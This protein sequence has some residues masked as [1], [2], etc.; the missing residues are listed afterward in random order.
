MMIKHFRFILLLIYV[1]VTKLANVLLK[2][3]VYE[4]REP[5]LSHSLMNY[6]KLIRLS[7]IQYDQL[8]V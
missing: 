4:E 7:F 5:Y 2:M 8:L 6:G 3:E 1:R